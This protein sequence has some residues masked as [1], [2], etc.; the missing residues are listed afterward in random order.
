MLRLLACVLCTLMVFGSDTPV[1]AASASVI[2]SCRSEDA[3]SARPP[4]VTST[5]SGVLL[6]TPAVCSGTYGGPFDQRGQVNLEGKA[7]GRTEDKKVGVLA[8][9]SIEVK[10]NQAN[11]VH[12]SDSDMRSRSF[13]RF[14]DFVTL[15]ARDSNGK[16]VP[17]GFMT[18]SAARTGELSVNFSDATFD[19]I[20]ALNGGDLSFASLTY[21]I[22]VNNEAVIDS[23]V[24][25]RAGEAMKL[26]PVESRR[27]FWDGS[28][29]LQFAME[30][31]VTAYASARGALAGTRIHALVLFSNTLAWAGISNVTDEFGQP[32]AS[33]S[34]LG[35]DGVDWATPATV[36]LPTPA[37]L[38]GAALAGL[39]LWRRAA[40]GHQLPNS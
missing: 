29:A 38:L 30:A 32:V 15:N 35:E 18:V 6:G 19:E 17:R 1:W 21:S 25:V 3:P 39:G 20:S 34:A 13:G 14:N 26:F 27:V 4:P 24:E 10:S 7:V 31:D 8:E 23:T 33:F 37:G 5:T 40:P 22:E 12:P 28:S 2:T 36:P 11:G 16:L 9:S